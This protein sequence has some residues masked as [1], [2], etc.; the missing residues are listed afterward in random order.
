MPQGH[1]EFC[2]DSKPR[3]DPE[4]EKVCMLRTA[5]LS[6]FNFTAGSKAHFLS[7]S[8]SNSWQKFLLTL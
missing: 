7:L 8:R 1:S 6:V 2:N 4:F 3:S 5:L